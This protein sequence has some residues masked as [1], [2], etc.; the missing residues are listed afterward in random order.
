MTNDFRRLQRQRSLPLAPSLFGCRLAIVLPCLS[1]FVARP[2]L[3]IESGTR[4]DMRFEAEVMVL[5]DFLAQ[6]LVIAAQR[7]VEGNV[8]THQRAVQR[9][10]REDR[11]YA[12]VKLAA[13]ILHVRPRQIPRTQGRDRKST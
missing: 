5:D 13:E 6:S 3:N 9:I 8:R 7:L 11:M 2:G 4:R 1:R 10:D 12:G